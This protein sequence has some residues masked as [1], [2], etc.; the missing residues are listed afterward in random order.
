MNRGVFL[1]YDPSRQSRLDARSESLLADKSDD[2][3]QSASAISRKFA[4]FLPEIGKR[5]T[6]KQFT[7][8]QWA[9]KARYYM[10]QGNWPETEN[11]LLNAVGLEPSRAALWH[12]LGDGY[13]AH[14][15]DHKAK[16]AFEHGIA[17]RH[18]NRWSYIHA[19]RLN[20]LANNFFRSFQYLCEGAKPWMETKPWRLE[21]QR[22]FQQWFD[23]EYPNIT[24]KPEG[25]RAFLTYL[26]DKMSVVGLPDILSLGHKD[27]PILILCGH[28][29]H[30]RVLNRQWFDEVGSKPQPVRIFSRSQVDLLIENLPGASTLIFNDVALDSFVM[31]AA[32]YAERYGIRRVFWAGSVV[33]GGVLGK[34]ESLGLSFE[35]LQYNDQTP[36]Q[37]RTMRSIALALL[38]D[39]VITTTPALL[40]PLHALGVNPFL[41]SSPFL[42]ALDQANLEAWKQD[43]RVFVSFAP[44]TPKGFT[45]Q[46]ILTH[47]EQLMDENPEISLFIEGLADH[48]EIKSRFMKRVE[49]QQEFLTDDARLAILTACYVAIDVRQG[50][51]DALWA[52]G[53][54]VATPVITLV[55]SNYPDMPPAGIVKTLEKLPQ[56]LTD[57][58]QQHQ[59]RLIP[60]RICHNAVQKIITSGKVET[61]P[62]REVITSRRPRVMIVNLF[63]P[64]Q[65]IGGASR[66]VEDNLRYFMT[67]NSDIDFS[68][69]AAD[70]VNDVLG[71][72]R[73][74]S[75]GSVPIFRVATPYE[76]DMYWRPHN[77]EIEAYTRRIVHLMQ[78]DLIHI[79]CPQRLTVGVT[80]VCRALD[81]PYMVTLHDSWWLSDYP[82][83]V[84]E[85][86][87]PVKLD[88][89]PSRQTYS[90]RI[91]LPR[92]LE[93]AVRLRDALQHA[94]LLIGV[95]KSYSEMYRRLGFNIL[96]VEN[97]ISPPNK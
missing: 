26:T 1:G 65:T 89:I 48:L 82:F 6:T 36:I 69:L 12:E 2:C 81:I 11:A 10:Q 84:C 41:I 33:S 91:G 37:P 55:N 70:D 14:G 88:K 29:M 52:A 94:T 38:C 18:P 25:Q 76:P 77:S 15:E 50:G 58:F 62:L 46:H 35:K 71:E 66:V 21:R 97:G 67:Q 22:L 60:L 78:P 32:L 4:A 51:I 75:W 28:E 8:E 57:M 80:D 83:L 17:T 27:G 7:A 13:L 85:D 87:S 24:T 20:T 44:E 72:T 61:G 49:R 96:T 43:K 92:S 64:P 56:M 3:T 63:A 19:T 79:H 53:A 34:E 93:R 47:L 39:D 73:V 59:K 86:G 9:G 5:L 40:P 42:R 31:D 74:D 30:P 23:H 45:H 90:H 16:E 54:I 95:S 68:V